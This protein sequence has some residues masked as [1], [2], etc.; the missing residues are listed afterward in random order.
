MTRGKVLVVVR[1]VTLESTMS[2]MSFGRLNVLLD[3]YI[4]NSRCARR[5]C[6]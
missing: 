5:R 3:V 2:Q 4:A 6:S 1:R